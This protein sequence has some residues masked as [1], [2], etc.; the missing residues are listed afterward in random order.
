MKAVVQDGPNTEL[1]LSRDVE[2]PVPGSRE[3]R[4]RIIHTAVNRMDLVQAKGLYVVPLGASPILG[5]EVSGIIDSVG[6]NCE[7]GFEVGDPVMALLEG[8]GYAE[9]ATCDERTVMSVLPGI[10]MVASSAIP[11]AFMTAYQ[12]LFLVA[13]ME[14]GE[15]VLIHAAAS[16]VGQA[17][18]QMAVNKGIT[19][20]ATSR[21]A[22]KIET[23]LSLGANFGYV[24]SPG[25]N[26]SDFVLRST[27]GKGVD[28]I[29]DPVG[30]AYLRDNLDS[31]SHDGRWVL[32]G[33]LS[34]G[35]INEE[36]NNNSPAG[37]MRKLLFKRVSLLST[38][39]RA[40]SYD[41][42]AS[43]IKRLI[44]DSEAG[45]GAVVA[46]KIKVHVDRVYDLEEVHEA[47]Q[48]MAANQNVGKIVM[49]IGTQGGDEL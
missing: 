44:E 38:T 15:S 1:I 31:I 41:Y 6:P 49:S 3:V 11:E 20:L 34:G 46:N 14:P 37:F 23:C 10:D 47:H 26:I 45:F 9:Y 17:A 2:M 7:L 13:K 35:V 30:S 21:S 42:K 27:D 39:L 16:S 22:Y 5:V 32:Y 18:I 33:L 8:G 43:L 25:S 40:R 24:T 36:M 4:I 12:L 28:V 19:V 48:L 29:L